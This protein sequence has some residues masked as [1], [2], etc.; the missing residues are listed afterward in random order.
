MVIYLFLLEEGGCYGSI[1]NIGYALI[2]KHAQSVVYRLTNKCH[3]YSP[4]ECITFVYVYVHALTVKSNYSHLA[5][6]MHTSI[7]KCYHQ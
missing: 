6:N 3:V 4:L 7:H 5:I 1:S 2:N